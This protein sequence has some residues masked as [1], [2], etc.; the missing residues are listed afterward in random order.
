VIRGTA[1]V[2]LLVLVIPSWADDAP[3]FPGELAALG[4]RFEELARKES[5]AR[6]E[7]STALWTEYLDELLALSGASGNDL[8][9]LSA[10]QVVQVRR[11]VQDRLSRLP[12]DVLRQYRRRAEAEAKKSAEEGQSTREPR[13]LQRVVDESFC[14]DAARTALELLGDLAFERG[15][16][17]EAIGWWRL[18]AVHHP[19]ARTVEASLQARRL[20]ARFFAGDRSDD[21]T[22]GLDTF[23][24]KHPDAEGYF[25]GSKGVFWK[26]LSEIAQRERDTPAI[27][28][29]DWPTFAGAPSR[30][31]IL[32]ADTLTPDSL[33]RLV[34]DGVQWTIPLTSEKAADR[35]RE[36]KSPG[37]F[38]RSL[39]FNPIIIGTL[40]LFA[41][42]RSVTAIDVKTGKREVWCDA[43]QL[44]EGFTPNLELPAPADLRYT[45]TAT[46]DCVLVRL[47]VQGLRSDRKERERGREGASVLACLNRI[48]D[49][50]GNRF[51][52]RVV[53]EGE[54]N[55]LTFEGSPV[56][57]SSQVYVAVARFESN[58]TTTAI[59]CYGLA[60]KQ[61]PTLRWKRDVCSTRELPAGET[62]YRHHLLTLV[63]GQL[64]Y[65]THSGAVVA[66]D[67]ATGRQTWGMRYRSVRVSEDETRPVSPRDL[68]PCV[69]ADGRLYVAPADS[70]LLLCL[71]PWT[72]A[73]IWE[74]DRIEVQHLLGVAKGRVLLTTRT[75][76]GGL[77]AINAND[78]SDRAG[79]FRSGADAPIYSVGRGLLAGDFIVWPTLHHVY[80]VRQEDGEQDADATMARGLPS[81]NMAF[82]DGILAVADREELHIYAP[83]RHRLPERKKD[84]DDRPRSAV[85]QF[86]LGTSLADAGQP[87]RAVELFRKAALLANQDRLSGELLRELAWRGEQRALFAAAERER[88]AG[89]I[90]QAATLID[91]AAGHYFPPALRGQGLQRSASFWL[92]AGERSRA[93]ACCQALLKDRELTRCALLDEH[94]QPQTAHRWATAWLERLE[95]EPKGVKPKSDKDSVSPESAS[96]SLPLLRSWSRTLA[97]DERA[98]IPEGTVDRFFTARGHVLTCHAAMTGTALWKREL[99]IS[100]TWIGLHG[101]NVLVAGADGVVCLTKKDGQITWEHWKSHDLS[102][103]QVV[104][105]RLF[106][107]EGNRRL[108]A[109]DAATG[110]VLWT[111]WGQSSFLRWPDVPGR[112]RSFE[113]RQHSVLL[114]DRREVLDASTGAVLDPLGPGA[115]VSI[116]PDTGK[117]RW[118]RSPQQRSTLNGLPVRQMTLGPDSFLAIVPRN[119]GTTLERIDAGSW[120]WATL[121]RSSAPAV[122]SISHDAGAIYLA[123]EDELSA[124]SL[125]NGKRLWSRPCTGPTGTWRTT[126]TGDW[127]LAWPIDRQRLAVPVPL[128]WG[129]LE[130]HLTWNAE[131]SVPLMIC[132]A[133]TG[134]LVQRL[135]L[136]ARCLNLRL[137]QQGNTYIEDEL[138]TVVRTSKGLLIRAGNGTSSSLFAYSAP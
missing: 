67:A 108:F 36:V 137:R 39:A 7:S 132:E 80:F 33:T 37:E 131:N 14:T 54:K 83:P 107:I 105:G 135:N 50:Q 41:D 62:R 16:F 129:R 82:G 88:R 30:N 38:A 8:A 64:Y 116:D 75:P 87:D 100:P 2:L 127:L 22:A 95:G 42:A 45:L 102:A 17:E 5:A 70:D 11:A 23:H 15:D 106:F 10:G 97:S 34:R 31:R 134:S 90:E 103:F 56:A 55:N 109:L 73:I 49:A 69:F 93:T 91:C 66:L 43:T 133:K 123:H 26:R 12:A 120:R 89:R 122:A 20:L 94:G 28:P 40:V 113:A 65:C 81:G 78:G 76:S 112:L 6:K 110:R 4:R 9:A 48:P 3:V 77:R 128:T 44:T 1:T 29:R 85:D 124:C 58:R 68:N 138:I 121:L 18:L 25:A 32:P 57:D 136:P 63:G 79:W 84:A 115:I 114:P 24:R 61:T 46:D 51:R 86:R 60:G 111:R 117:Q 119:Q 52:W 99:T 101:E 21:W 125:D 92:R 35:P 59:H 72:G 47:G 98:L 126:R 130:C 13:P 71:D 53:L 96:L 19:D 74:R 104:A 118:S 27:A